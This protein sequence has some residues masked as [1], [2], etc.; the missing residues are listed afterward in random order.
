MPTNQFHGRTIFDTDYVE[1][2]ATE[3]GLRSPRAITLDTNYVQASAT[4]SKIIYPGMI[5]SKLASG[6]GRVF[7]ASRATAAT[8]TSA[9]TL[10]VRNG[11][12]FKVGDVLRNGLTGTTAIGTIQSIAGNVITLTAN[13]ANAVAIGDI[14]NV[15]TAGEGGALTDLLGIIVSPIDINHDPNDIAAYT[16]GTVYGARLPFWDAQLTPIFPEIT[17]FPYPNSFPVL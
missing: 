1:I 4:G 16:S 3:L 2:I 8:A 7:P 17:M 10:T 12:I 14:V 5:L 13:A 11:S 15:S 9:N 6:L